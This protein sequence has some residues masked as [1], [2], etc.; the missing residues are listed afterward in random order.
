LYQEFRDTIAKYFP[1]F[2]S[3][4][5]HIIW[6]YL[7]LLIMDDFCLKKIVYIANAYIN[8]AFWPSHFKTTTT[9][10]IP[11]HNKELYNIPKAFQYIVL[12]KT[13][14]K[15]IEKVISNHFQFY[16]TSNSFFCHKLYLVISPSFL[17]Q[18][19]WS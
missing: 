19:S 8:L 14:G 1:F 9:V 13:T 11:K 12:L 18:F 7:R 2:T 3:G 10:V 5:D 16:I 4:S 6:R 15:L 17:Q